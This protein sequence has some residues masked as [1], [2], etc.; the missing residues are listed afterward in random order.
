MPVLF[1]ASPI[2]QSEHQSETYAP[3]FQYPCNG[4]SVGGYG[5]KTIFADGGAIGASAAGNADYLLK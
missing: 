2:Q 5:K 1:P 3:H 4:E